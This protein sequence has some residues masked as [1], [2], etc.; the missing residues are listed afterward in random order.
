MEQ[1]ER[2]VNGEIGGVASWKVKQN[3]L[4]RKINIIGEGGSNELATTTNRGDHPTTYLRSPKIDYC[5]YKHIC[6]CESFRLAPSE[7]GKKPRGKSSAAGRG[8]HTQSL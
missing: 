7:V 5:C 1:L 3:L 8:T 4:L 6:M 2:R